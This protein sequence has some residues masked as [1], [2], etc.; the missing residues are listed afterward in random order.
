MGPNDLIAAFISNKRATQALTKELE[1]NKLPE[2][3][4]LKGM[5]LAESAPIR[6]HALI[7]ALQKAEA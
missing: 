6:P 2:D 4:A 3:V 1:N 5:Q 7:K